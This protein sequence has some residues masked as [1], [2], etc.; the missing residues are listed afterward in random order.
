LETVWNGNYQKLIAYKKSYGDCDVPVHWE[1]DPSLGAWVAAQRALRKKGWLQLKRITLLKQLGFR[2]T[3]RVIKPHSIKNEVQWQSK[4]YGKLLPFVNTHGH[5]NVR[6][7]FPADLVLY[8]WV[9]KQRYLFS[10]GVLRKDRMA[11]LDGVGFVYRVDEQRM[12]QL[13][14]AAASTDLQSSTR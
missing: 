14:E 1:E 5:C 4:F 8:E 2:W 12:A 7:V 9:R 6:S 10:K 11:L 13:K 3:F